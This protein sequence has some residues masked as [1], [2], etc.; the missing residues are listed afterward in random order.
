MAKNYINTYT[1]NSILHLMENGSLTVPAFQ[2]GFVWRKENVKELFESINGGYPIGIL[3]AVEHDQKHFEVAS[4]KLTLF[5]EISPENILSTKRL[6]I[7]DGSQ[8]LASLYNVLLGKDNSFA[9][10]YD[11]ERKKFS[12]PDKF[13]G[14][15]VF[16]NMSSLFKVREYMQLQAE[17]SKLRNSETLLEE[18]YEMH[19]RFTNYQVPIQVITDVNDPDIVEIFMR[20]NTRGI[21]LS[22]DEVEKSTKYRNA[23]Q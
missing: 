19:N 1:I 10:I 20:I 23:E 6:W 8:R 21:S 11:L 13:K 5:P 16:L 17:I 2:R 22:K 18:L 9:L 14:K 7:L 3:I 15:S 12:F 4:N